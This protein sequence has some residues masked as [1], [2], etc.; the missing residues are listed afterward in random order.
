MYMIDAGNETTMGHR[1]WIMSPGLETI[2]VGSTDNYSCMEVLHSNRPQNWVAYPPPGP[3]PIQAT[4]DRWGR[5]IDQTGWTVQFDGLSLGQPQVTVTSFPLGTSD[6]LNNQ[7]GEDCP[8]EV[9]DLA[10]NYGSSGAINLI[11]Q[12]WTTQVN[13]EYVVRLEGQGDAIEYTVEVVDCDSL[14]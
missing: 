5:S 14:P 2:G 3:F 1:R 8:V 11:P 12:G 4:Q 7:M 6:S 10:P 13:M 9:I